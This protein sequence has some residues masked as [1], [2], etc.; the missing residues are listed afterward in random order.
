MLVCKAISCVLASDTGIRTPL[1]TL[2]WVIQMQKQ[3]RQPLVTPVTG[4]ASS[5]AHWLERM[6]LVAVGRR[7]PL[8]DTWSW[9][10]MRHL[11]IIIKLRF[12]TVQ[13]MP[14]VLRII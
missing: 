4:L 5:L 13:I 14:L 10:R 11:N 9:R 1:L 7:G 12:S 6:L 8:T 3:L 2:L